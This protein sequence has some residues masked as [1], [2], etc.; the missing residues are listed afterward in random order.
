MASTQDSR[1]LIE[2]LTN[3]V[4][5][6][7]RLSYLVRKPGNPYKRTNHAYPTFRYRG[8]FRFK[9][10]FSVTVMVVKLAILPCCSLLECHK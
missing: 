9:V 8:M 10:G 7:F 6:V 5:D 3:L 1:M 4:L 2:L